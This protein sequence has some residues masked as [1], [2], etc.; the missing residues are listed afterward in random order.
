M[1]TRTFGES[2][3]FINDAVFGLDLRNTG[4]YNLLQKLFY[5]NEIDDRIENILG[6]EGRLLLRTLEQGRRNEEN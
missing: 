1:A 3:S 6:S 5:D 4:Y 2:I